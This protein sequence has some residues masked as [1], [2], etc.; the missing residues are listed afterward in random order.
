MGESGLSSPQTLPDQL[1]YSANNG[2]CQLQG[3]CE[4]A[5]L[6]EL[7]EHQ[8]TMATPVDATFDQDRISE[9]NGG[10]WFEKVGF[11]RQVRQRRFVRMS[12]D[13]SRIEWGTHPRGPCKVIPVADISRIDFGDASRSFRCF[14]FGHVNRPHPVLCLSIST[15]FRSLDLVARSEREVE[16]WVLGLNAVV[17]YPPERQRFT[18]QEFLLR[19]AMLKLEAGDIHASYVMSDSEA[20]SGSF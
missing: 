7:E 17:A 9:M 18:A 3:A 10:S 19:R 11:R 1:R 4:I 8:Y 2:P 20:V 15:A 16:S 12:F 14:E 6:G 5:M 13:L